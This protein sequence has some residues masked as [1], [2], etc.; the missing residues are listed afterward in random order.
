MT[1]GAPLVTCPKAVQFDPNLTQIFGSNW[2]GA[3]FTPERPRVAPKGLGIVWNQSD[4]V[5]GGSFADFC[6]LFRPRA[7]IGPHLT[8]FDPILP[9]SAPIQFHQWRPQ[10]WR[11]QAVGCFWRG[12]KG[13]K[14]RRRRRRFFNLETFEHPCMQIPNVLNRGSAWKRTLPPGKSP[15]WE[16]LDTWCATGNLPQSCRICPKFD[17]NLTQN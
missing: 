11:C 7:P 8:Q 6:T 5:W 4:D 12:V 13:K 15:F 17:P 9:P 3:I 16:Q 1:H 2:F 14:M 10:A